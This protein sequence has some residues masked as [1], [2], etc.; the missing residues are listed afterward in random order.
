MSHSINAITSKEQKHPRV[1]FQQ[2]LSS[3]GEPRDVTSR[4]IPT[5]LDAELIGDVYA[6]RRQFRHLAHKMR[7]HYL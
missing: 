7:H 1:Q 2:Y 5:D 6:M 4:G 3:A